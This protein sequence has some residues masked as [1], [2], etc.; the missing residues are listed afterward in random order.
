MNVTEGLRGN[1]FFV[2]EPHPE[3]RQAWRCMP[4]R[5]FWRW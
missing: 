2:R 5:C 3:D 4:R 1:A